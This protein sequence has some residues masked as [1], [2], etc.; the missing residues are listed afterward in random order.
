MK[1]DLRNVARGIRDAFNRAPCLHTTVLAA[2]LLFLHQPNGLLSP[3]F[4]AEDGTIFFVE[5][6]G[7]AL[8]AIPE[9]YAGYYHLVPRLLAVV[10]APLP[11]V[12]APW[13]FNYACFLFT[14]FVVAYTCKT[15][16]GLPWRPLAALA[17]L[18]V[19]YAPDLWINMANLHWKGAAFMIVHLL[20]FAQDKSGWRVAAES[21]L[22]V[23]LGLSGPFSLLLA[24]AY[25]FGLATYPHKQRNAIPTAVILVTAVIQTAAIATHFEPQAAGLPDPLLVL[26][27]IGTRTVL[28]LFT[29]ISA[30]GLPNLI[31]L[32]LMAWWLRSN[33]PRRLVILYLALGA[34]LAS[35]MWKFRG[36][37]QVLGFESAGPRYFWLPG[38]IFLWLALDVARSRKGWIRWIFVVILVYALG[39]SVDHFQPEQV[40]DNDWPLHA[41]ILEAGFEACV[42]LNPR[43]LW[44]MCRQG[45]KP[46]SLAPDFNRPEG[47]R[48]VSGLAA[49]GVEAEEE[50]LTGP[51]L[52]SGP[53]PA[54][55]PKAV[56]DARVPEGG[57]I[58]VVR[59]LAKGPDRNLAVVVEAGSGASARR[60]TITGRDFSPEPYF[61]Y[62]TMDLRD[63]GGRRLRLEIEDASCTEN[64]WLVVEPLFYPLPPDGR[65]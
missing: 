11:T 44:A 33:D 38:V 56:L 14:L 65:P 30:L 6:L 52:D 27:V 64:G 9:T 37:L 2:V 41:R 35:A 21:A 5:T 7:Q 39:Y 19:P 32:G 12:A 62:L 48:L 63:S 23:L 55:G 1:A 10:A 61:D 20:T 16:N 3:S 43:P 57:G 45:E 50:L 34:L 22:L 40:P 49:A 28:G 29:H 58:L 59:V 60:Q 51:A 8:A 17:L 46:L 47:F 31:L 25:L 13:V 42:P 4:W 53:D 15:D 26:D 18:L 24:P 36:D 54:C